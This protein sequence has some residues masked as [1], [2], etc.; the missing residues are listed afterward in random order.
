MKKNG[1]QCDAEM[2]IKLFE[3]NS[4]NR[5]QKVIKFAD[6]LCNSQDNVSISMNGQWGSGKT[7][8]IKQVKLLIDAYSDKSTLSATQITQIKQI[9]QRNH[10]KALRGTR[11]LY[12]DAWIHDGDGDPLQSLLLDLINSPWS[13]YD[14]DK[15]AS[16]GDD[17]L[18]ICDIV[19]GR[20]ISAAI[21]N[22]RSSNNI[23]E[24]VERYEKVS[25]KVRNILD[26]IKNGEGRLVIFIDELDRCKPSFAVDL[27]E[28]IKHY[29]SDN[30]IT[31]VYSLNAKELQHTIKSYYGDGF[32]A[33]AYLD[34]FFD[35][36][37][38]IPEVEPKEY[39][40]LFF[41]NSRYGYACIALAQYFK[42]S[43]RTIEMFANSVKLACSGAVQSIG[44][45]DYEKIIII[46]YFIPIAFALNITNKNKYDDFLHG[47]GRDIIIDLNNC[48]DVVPSW[49][50]SRDEKQG[51]ITDAD[52]ATRTADIY[53]AMFL[54][55][56]DGGY[57]VSIGNLRFTRETLSL[58]YDILSFT[59][60]LVV[61]QYQL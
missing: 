39:A 35:L 56:R 21:K 9:Y 61:D 41:D 57:S 48:I 15:S 54:Y 52:V 37:C 33:S 40:K 53:D 4:L 23:F 6:L 42:M 28:T 20:D 25:E 1:K 50:F 16:I 59:S 36:Q 58:F 12:Y 2:L 46:D 30:E 45:Y 26:T 38:S 7:F 8:F 27:L 11:S 44:P 47:R 10:E 31:V 5:Q 22:M 19:T 51:E 55:D 13:N 18:S 3:E 29:F 17:L 49:I 24:D 14:I 43:L 60:W 32:D 34:R